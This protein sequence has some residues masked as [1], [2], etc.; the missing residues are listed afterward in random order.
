MWFLV[1]VSIVNA[2]I[3]ETEADNHPSRPQLQFRIDLAKTL[4]GDFSCRSF[5][6]S[7]GRITA[8]H[9]PVK[10]TKKHCKRCL[11]RKRSK[12]CRMGCMSC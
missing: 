4:V 2:H 6:V 1:D 7:E 11:K 10:A 9:W 3:L 12:F 5:S 8:G